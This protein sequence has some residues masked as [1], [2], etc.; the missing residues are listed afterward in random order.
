MSKFQIYFDAE[1]SALLANG[2]YDEFQFVDDLIVAANSNPSLKQVL[3]NVKELNQLLQ[4][5]ID[6]HDRNGSGSPTSFSVC[7]DSGCGVYTRDQ[8]KAFVK[9]MNVDGLIANIDKHSSIKAE[10]P[11]GVSEKKTLLRIIGALTNALADQGPQNLSKE[12]S[13]IV[14]TDESG[15]I[16]FLK[17]NGYISVGK[18]TLHKHI[19]HGLAEIEDFK[20]Q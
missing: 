9:P 7:P 8:L 13:P 16:G 14:G 10:K 12:D 17:M 15:I 5:N 18:S 19:S 20:K 11:L 6:E 1:A 4:S 2:I 3:E